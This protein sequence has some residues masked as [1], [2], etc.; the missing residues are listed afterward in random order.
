MSSFAHLRRL[1]LNPS[2]IERVIVLLDDAGKVRDANPQVAIILCRAALEELSRAV[3]ARRFPRNGGAS[4][5]GQKERFERLITDCDRS[6]NLAEGRVWR[7]F[8]SRNGEWDRVADSKERATADSVIGHLQFWHT[9]SWDLCCIHDPSMRGPTPVY[10]P[11]CAMQSL[12]ECDPSGEYVAALKVRIQ[13]ESDLRESARWRYSDNAEKLIDAEQC[14]PEAGAAM[15]QREHQVASSD[16]IALQATLGKNPDVVRGFE[17]ERSKMEMVCGS[18]RSDALHNAALREQ[19][20]LEL[21]RL[22]KTEQSKAEQLVE[23]RAELNRLKQVGLEMAESERSA[24]ANAQKVQQ[25]C[26]AA[27]GENEILRQRKGS[28]SHSAQIQELLRHSERR[29]V[30][31]AEKERVLSGEVERYRQ[32]RKEAAERAEV[33]DA[34]VRH[35]RDE[36][37]CEAE[38]RQQLERAEARRRRYEDEY[39]GLGQAHEFFQLAIDGDEKGALPPLSSLGNFLD[40][41]FDRYARRLEASHASGLCTLRVVSLRP[42]VGDPERCRAWEVEE[43]NL[44]LMGE[45]RGRLGIARL[46][47]SGVERKPGFSVFVRES[48]PPLSEFGVSGR[49]LRLATALR[50]GAALAAELSARAQARMAVSWPDLHAIGVQ[51]GSPRLFEPTAPHFGDLGPPEDIEKTAAECVDLSREMLEVGWAY[52]VAHATLRVIGILPSG[53]TTAASI[54]DLDPQ[55]LR[56]H[57]EELRRACDE[58]I[59]RAALEE[60]AVSLVGVMRERGGK[61]PRLKDLLNAMRNPLAGS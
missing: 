2:A 56:I 42:G 50:F 46:V 52:S 26:A 17:A 19:V 3:D 34:Q 16:S 61:Q 9:T 23:M 24:L 21:E 49:T 15:G 37:A 47:A 58:S 11:P 54:D 7:Q 51:R 60:L 1:A 41:G 40:L 27:R 32:E 30:E 53:K 38:A 45:L 10:V 29:V 31:L 6:R 35:L 36:I 14:W 44:S 57:L 18:L 25:E 55:W 59:A 8:R 48:A 5:D 43:R 33:V 13:E 22:R 39:P 28:S 4:L 12:L 20:V